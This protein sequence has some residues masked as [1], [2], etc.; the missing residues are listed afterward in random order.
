VLAAAIQRL[1]DDPARRGELSRDGRAALEQGG[2]G[3]QSDLYLKVYD[4]LLV[5]QA[6][7]PTQRTASPAV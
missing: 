4:S 3:A 5:G 7:P 6:R 1:H 2:W